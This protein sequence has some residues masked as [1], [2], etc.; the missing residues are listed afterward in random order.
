MIKKLITATLLTATPFF[1]FSGN[2]VTGVDYVNLKL[3]DG[4]DSITLGGVAATFGYTEHM[5]K[6]F[7]LTPEVRLGTGVVSDTYN[8]AGS[9][10]DI[11]LSSFVS[12]SVKTELD[13]TNRIYLFAAPS[14]SYTDLTVS[15]NYGGTSYEGSGDD[16]DFGLGA[17]A[18]FKI[19]DQISTEFRY[20]AYDDTDAYSIGLRM[21]F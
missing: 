19:T 7:R 14:W 10:L 1:A 17:G 9:S 2:M 5:G 8:Y 11:E 21:N 15:V 6:M 20:E 3:T 4:D 12:L 16:S 13:L 18:G